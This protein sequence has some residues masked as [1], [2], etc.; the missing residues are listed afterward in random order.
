MC[1]C[2]CLCTVYAQHQSVHI[3]MSIDTSTCGDITLTVSQPRPS[4]STVQTN[5]Q[6]RVI[7]GKSSRT[8]LRVFCHRRARTQPSGMLMVIGERIQ[9]KVQ[10][11]LSDSIC[12]S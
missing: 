10:L 4:S 6:P 2:L 5:D 8:F 12:L 11:I 9:A 3:I 1:L 7:A